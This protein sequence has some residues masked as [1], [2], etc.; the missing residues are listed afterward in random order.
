MISLDEL[1]T[2]IVNLISIKQ[3]IADIDKDKTGSVTLNEFEDIIKV[4]NPH[5]CPYDL[6][7]ALREFSY[8]NNTLLVDYKNFLRIVL[9]NST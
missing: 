3:R 4:S 2:K 5:L 6:K 7:E 9:L 1:K 8:E